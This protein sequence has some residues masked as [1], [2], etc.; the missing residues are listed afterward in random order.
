MNNRGLAA[1][2]VAFLMASSAS[3]QNSDSRFPLFDNAPAAQHRCPF[4]FV[5]WLDTK[6]DTYN[7]GGPPA[8]AD[9]RNGAYM[10]QRDADQMDYKPMQP[11]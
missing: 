3:A 8:G 5:V 11:H 1:F 9:L 7:M 10:C 6:T 2:V 4:D